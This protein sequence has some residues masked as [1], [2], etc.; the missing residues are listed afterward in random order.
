MEQAGHQ[1]FSGFFRS[2]DFLELSRPI[3]KL[4]DIS[5]VPEVVSF[6]PPAMSSGKNA[7]LV[8]PWVAILFALLFYTIGLGSDH[9]AT[10]GDEL[11]YAQMTRLTAA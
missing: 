8:A 4:L 10:N 7:S 2:I 1:P 6:Q 9:L 11:V 3:Q 5:L